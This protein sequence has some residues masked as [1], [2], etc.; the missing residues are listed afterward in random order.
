MLKRLVILMLTLLV[1]TAIGVR[2]AQDPGYVLFA[3]GQWTVEM[4]MWIFALLFLALLILGY[5]LLRILHGIR[6]SRRTWRRWRAQQRLE[7]SMSAVHNGLLALTEGNLPAAE[8]AFNR[9][10]KRN[11]RAGSGYFLLSQLATSLNLP[12]LAQRYYDKAAAS[13]P[14]AE[15]AL[16]LTRAQLLAQSPATRAQAIANL[17]ALHAR[18]PKHKA[19]LQTLWDLHQ[20]Q[21]DLASSLALLPLCRQAGLFAGEEAQD[22]QKQMTVQLMQQYRNTADWPTL[23]ALWDT[24]P[25]KYWYDAQVISQVSAALSATGKGQRAEKLI[26]KSLRKQYHPQLVIAY[27][28]LTDIDQGKRL[29]QIEKWAPKHPDDPDL[30]FVLGKLCSDCRLW[31]KA[32]DYLERASAFRMDSEVCDALGNVLEHLKEN[33]AAMDIYRQGLHY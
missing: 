13:Q 8:K 30:L 29:A 10:S 19:V 25:R 21:Q 16:G 27:S 24:L 32:K 23:L 17:Q 15:V 5:G 3:Y 6:N 9:A 31:G 7:K 14:N 33:R 20:Q 2:I 12:K 4:P 28:Q 18:Y 22:K 26:K 11:P 1:A